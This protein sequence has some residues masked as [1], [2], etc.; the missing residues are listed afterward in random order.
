MKETGISNSLSKNLSSFSPIVF[1]ANGCIWTIQ[2]EDN[3]NSTFKIPS[4]YNG[5]DICYYTSSKKSYNTNDAFQVAA[6]NLLKQLDVDT[7]N[8]IDV[9]LNSQ[10]LQIS[11]SEVSGIP[12]RW[13]TEVQVRTWN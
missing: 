6:Y 7:N 12:Y 9:E 2:F 8:K 1:S 3:T 11:Q 4:N 13:S 10:S 5:T